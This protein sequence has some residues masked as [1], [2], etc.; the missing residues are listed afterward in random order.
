MLLFYINIFQSQAKLKSYVL[1]IDIHKNVFYIYAL[2]RMGTMC[3]H[4]PHSTFRLQ[5]VLLGV[6][7][8]YLI[9]LQKTNHSL[10]F[11]QGIIASDL[12]CIVEYIMQCK[13]L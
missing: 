8:K 5:V 11:I 9:L 7:W 13:Y 2:S 6:R 3:F 12:E 10:G 1:Y 4:P